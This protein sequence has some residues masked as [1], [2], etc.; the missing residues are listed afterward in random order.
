AKCGEMGSELRSE[1]AAWQSERRGLLARLGPPAQQESAPPGEGSGPKGREAEIEEPPG[2]PD[3]HDQRVPSTPSPSSPGGSSSATTCEESVTGEG[4]GSSQ[5]TAREEVKAPRGDETTKEVLEA[6]RRAALEG[7][8]V[9]RRCSAQR[10]QA[11]AAEEAARRLKDRLL[12]A[13]DLYVGCDGRQKVAAE[14]DAATDTAAPVSAASPIA[15]CS[16][17]SE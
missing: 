14:G 5:A 13:V 4:S 16:R 6:L 11:V 15:L 9:E 7:A 2:A 1:R 8:E 10:S 3:C 12:A 17:R